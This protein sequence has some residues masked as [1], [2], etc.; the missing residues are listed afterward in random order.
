MRIRIFLFLLFLC[1]S[2]LYTDFLFFNEKKSTTISTVTKNG[3]VYASLDDFKRVIKISF[4]QD[5]TKKRFI[6][7]FS[8]HTLTF[9]P[10]NPYYLLDNKGK[11]MNLPFI[12]IEGKSYISLSDIEMVLSDAT[13][14]DVFLICPLNSIVMDRSTFNPDSI[15]LKDEK[16]KISFTLTSETEIITSIVDDK[17]GKLELT[18]FN[19]V[20]KPTIIPPSNG[21]GEIKKIVLNQG[22]NKA[23]LS[24]FYDVN[25]VRKIEKELISPGSSIRITFYKKEEVKPPKEEKPKKQ[26][27]INKVIIDPG[28]GGKDPGAVGPTGLTEKEIVLKISKELKKILTREGFTV[29]MT[30]D[31]DSFVRLR[32]RST[33]AN[34]LGADLFVSIHCNAT[35]GR[36]EAGGFETFFLSTAKTSWARAVEAKENAVIEFETPSEKKSLLEFIFYDLLQN[37]H[38]RESSD[39]AD[40]IQESM[41]R[42]L[43]IE[44][45]GVKQANFHVMREIY[46]PSV[47]VEAAFISNSEEEKQLKKQSFRKKIAQGIA[48]G[49]L[50]FKK[51]YEKKL[52]K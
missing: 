38:L 35:G 11:K 2:F 13:D 47:L 48:Y 7:N 21:K 32:Q 44:D 51:V 41:A 40:F 22:Q 37:L 26:Y 3:W 24:F 9:I 12:S 16:D 28:H 34:N 50:E 31:D 10:E 42:N 39:L 19:A 45:R 1:P 5:I 33:M 6:L 15:I 36:K 20:C 8:E 30:R 29:L 18:L 4:L 25:K 17:N 46:M 52:N 27:F 43:T 49:I 14:K 23:V